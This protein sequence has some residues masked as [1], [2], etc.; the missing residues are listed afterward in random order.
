MIAAGPTWFEVDTRHPT[1]VRQR[2]TRY[3]SSHGACVRRA[4]GGWTEV[5][6]GDSGVTLVRARFGIDPSVDSGCKTLAAGR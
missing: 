2:Y 6:P 5:D 1:V 3:W 4:P